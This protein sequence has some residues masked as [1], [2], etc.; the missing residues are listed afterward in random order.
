MVALVAI[1][2][3]LLVRFL[4]G[5]AKENA[6]EELTSVV[7]LKTNEISEWFEQRRGDATRIMQTPFFTRAA[8]GF[9]ADP[10]QS[11]E[12]DDLLTWM[13]SYLRNRYY[14]SV[15]LLDTAGEAVLAACKPGEVV[16]DYARDLAL[17][18]MS[19]GEVAISDLHYGEGDNL[20]H[21]DLIAP[22]PST[23]TSTPAAG[24]VLLRV[25][26]YTYLYPLIQS[27]PSPS[28]SAETLIVR[29]EDGEIV[30][31][32]ELRY[33]E[34]GPLSLRLPAGEENLPAA[35][36]AG[37]FEG[38]VEGTDY[39][40]VEVLAAVRGVPGT[41]WYVVAKEDASEVYASISAR[42]WLAVGFTTMMV[43]AL[44]LLM[45]L[46]WIRKRGQFYRWQYAMEAERSTLARHCEYLT[47]YANDII[48]LMDEAWR[49]VEVNEQAVKTYGYTREELLGMSA[50][51]LRSEAARAGFA[52]T[53]R[54][55]DIGD[56]TVFET[57]HVR[58]DGT[59]FP[60]EISARVIET[61]GERFYQGIIRDISER[62]R[63]QEELRER[64]V[65]MRR[66]TDNMLDLISQIDLEGN[67][68][69]LSPSNER[70]LG[71]READLLGT[72]VMELVHPDD[73]PAVAD[74]Y[75]RS[76][77]ELVPGKVEFRARKA[78]GTYIWVE[79]VGN[80]L[81]N[82]AGELIGAI[83]ATRDISDRK[84]AED[85]A[86]RGRMLLFSAFEMVPATVILLAP[87]YT[88]RYANSY[89][90]ELF[91]DPG[92]KKC[93]EVLYGRST[94][95]EEYCPL[96]IIETGEPFSREWSDES[97]MCFL[98]HY[99]PFEDMDGQGAVLEMGIDVTDRK[100]IEK[101]LERINRCFL[102]LG[103]KPLENV[104]MIVDAGQEIMQAVGMHYSHLNRG[105]IY[106]YRTA[107]DG[108]GRKHLEMDDCP[109]CHTVIAEGG[110]EPF[111]LEDLPASGYDG[112]LPDAVQDGFGSYLAYPVKAHG[113]TVGV[114]G[115]L[116]G[117][118]GAFS[119]E[120]REIMGML[121]RAISVEE[122]RLDHEEELRAFI[123]IASH[124]LRHPMTIIKGYAAT[125]RLYR[126]RMDDTTVR[127]VLADIEKGVD[128]L[129]KLV[130]QLLDASRMERD[131]LVLE[132]A[133]TDIEALLKNAVAEMRYK[134]P[135]RDFVLDLR[136]REC[137][138][139]AEAERIGQ[140]LVILM[141]NA[142][143][144]S[145]HD[146]LVEVAMDVNEEGK[147]V[148]SVMD[149][150]V[151]VPEEHR[152]R[153][154]ERFFQ[155]GD[156]S[157]HSSEGIGLGLHIAREIIEAHGGEIWYEPREGGGSIFSF[158]LP[159]P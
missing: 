61:K 67:F 145:A 3:V 107:S 2:G 10:G 33:H 66:L 155:V 108:A 154:F 98:V 55:L 51:L 46:L 135:A 96:G 39:R 49:I 59:T 8:R 47:R 117:E 124:E 4:Q 56:G 159:R 34:G 132:K 24:A 18:A 40:G 102:E 150:G 21:I 90:R 17:E 149:R 28:D 136:E 111:V 52:Q 158:T 131:K 69:Y 92:G 157:Y 121:A 143:N 146:S 134:V 76:N 104:L 29:V 115:L 105:G 93:Y 125:L 89:F 151:G 112:L 22:I 48:V 32:N 129:E 23:S 147:V 63:M 80:P 127:G 15:F 19:K 44:G 50:P 36:A 141:E 152:G 100:R 99:F 45:G 5:N 82:E 72:N 9:L 7:N 87:D 153:I 74:S 83:F 123:D 14:R 156:P 142:V 73:L 27:W 65:F 81:Y 26:P 103:T 16:G 120:E 94:P 140:V 30:F 110:G 25:D 41:A 116:R 6:L 109:I 139:E 20:V 130:Y 38:V 42:T 119:V 138:V 64:E 60:V 70:V 53:V 95:C 43:I 37:G 54:E 113:V 85:E 11:E 122:E 57:E 126:D 97:G 1:S 71:Y 118:R 58:K 31:L 91:G 75:V 62:R 114:L 12:R 101:R 128:R 148:I 68:V 13:E 137:R 86:E 88:F 133:E 79:S 106:V 35:L 84:M 144:Y 77:M 78:D